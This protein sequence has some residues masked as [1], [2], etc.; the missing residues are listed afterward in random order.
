MKAKNTKNFKILKNLAGN[1]K[2]LKLFI[3]KKLKW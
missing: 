2:H 3:I 1:Q